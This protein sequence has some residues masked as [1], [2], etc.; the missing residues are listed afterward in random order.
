[1]NLLLSTVEN[2]KA[3]VIF[4]HGAGAN[5]SHEFMSEISLLLNELGINVVRFNFPFMDKR[6][7]TGIKYP[8]DRMPK[9]LVCYED[10]IR[11]VV[12]QLAEHELP[13]FIGG[14]SMGSRVA[15]SIV[16]APELLPLNLLNKVSGV[17]CLGYPFH[18]AKK[19]E[20]LRLEPLFD[21]SKPVLI[22]QGDR[23]TLGNKAEII[24]YELAAHCQCVFLEDGDHSL[25]PRV[26]SGFT[27]QAHINSAVEE[28][29]QFI[30]KLAV[31][32]NA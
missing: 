3:Q 14:K 12:E 13:L 8:P 25:K 6:A 15:A 21:A 19:P 29:V 32:N 26:K 17:F 28:I 11:H 20:K 22:V 5:M 18:P 30:E 1:M 16:A 4:A 23:D 10:V 24:S 27:Y 9:L 2:A 31:N 7:L